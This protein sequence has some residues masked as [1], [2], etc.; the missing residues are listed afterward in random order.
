M[1]AQ[2]VGSPTVGRTAHRRNPYR[3]RSSPG[4]LDSRTTGGCAIV[5]KLGVAAASAALIGTIA[6]VLPAG[7]AKADVTG[8]A[9]PDPIAGVCGSAGATDCWR[10]TSLSDATGNPGPIPAAV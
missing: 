9:L 7:V 1:R 3:A 2:S 6:A 10:Y 5:R 4:P 8:V